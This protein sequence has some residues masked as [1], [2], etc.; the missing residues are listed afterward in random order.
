MEK[1]PFGR[2]EISRTTLGTRK[3][4]GPPCEWA[5]LG[6]KEAGSKPLQSGYFE[7]VKENGP[8]QLVGQVSQEQT[9]GVYRYNRLIV[10]W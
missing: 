9:R 1:A 10:E 8:P 2:V 5:S 7:A 3:E 4:N 6:N